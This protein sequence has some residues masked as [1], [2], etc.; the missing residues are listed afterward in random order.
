M[1]KG[2]VSLAVFWIWIS[3]GSAFDGRPDPD[4]DLGGL[5]RKE[6]AIPKADTQEKRIK[7]NVIGTK[8]VNA[9]SF[10]CSFSLKN[11]LFLLYWI[12]IPMDLHS[13]SKLHLEAIGIKTGSGSA[14]S[15]SG[16]EAMVTCFCQNCDATTP[17]NAFSKMLLLFSRMH[18]QISGLPNY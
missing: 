3:I 4:L 9:I 14:L 2:P 1:L 17:K 12:R 18:Y 15:F 13:L 16:F 6:K 11:G 7:C 8:W 10:T 5:K